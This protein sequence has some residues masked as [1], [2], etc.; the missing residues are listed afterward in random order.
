MAKYTVEDITLTSIGDAIRAKNNSKELIKPSDMPAAIEAID[1]VP[2]EAFVLGN[3][4]SLSYMFHEY[5]W[6]WFWEKYKDKITTQDIYI[7]SNMFDSNC[8]IE[9]IP[10]DLNCNE[11]HG[12]TFTQCFYNTEHLK[13]VPYIVGKVSSL[14]EFLYNSSVEN[15]PEDWADKINWETIHTKDYTEFKLFHSASKLKKIP[16]SLMAQCYNGPQSIPSYTMYDLL[17]EDCY[18]LLSLDDIPVQEWDCTDSGAF[19]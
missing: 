3:T 11:V 8:Y 7:A 1:T 4:L 17:F 15:I 10:F 13:T 6:R 12:G 19:Q 2:D 9:E 14:K 5:Q 16:A 18:C